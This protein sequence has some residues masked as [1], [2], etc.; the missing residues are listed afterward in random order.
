[1][2]K[3]LMHT[4]TQ[5]PAARARGNPHRRQ[6]VTTCRSHPSYPEARDCL[7]SIDVMKCRSPSLKNRRLE[8]KEYDAKSSGNPDI[9]SGDLS[10]VLQ[11][12][13]EG[14]F[15]Q[16]VSNAWAGGIS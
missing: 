12:Q 11:A 4:K 2:E 13:I 7:A 14:A 8:G 9:H 10:C 3:S 5:D 16:Q 1:M 15:A 6:L